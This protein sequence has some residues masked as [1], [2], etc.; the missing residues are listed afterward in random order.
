M[1]KKLHTALKSLMLLFMLSA[2]TVTYSQVGTLDT[3]FDPDE[4]PDFVV[5]IAAPL[6]DGKILIGGSFSEY[7]AVSRKGI[8][9]INADGTLDTSFNPGTGIP[10]M[11]GVTTITINDIEV[12][13]N[14]KILVAGA[15]PTFNDAAKNCMVRLNTDGSLDATF[16]LDARITNMVDVKAITLQPD[17]K[18]II[19]GSFKITGARGG[20]ARLNSDGSIDESFEFTLPNASTNNP[21]F[22]TSLLQ[23]D[24]KILVGGSI[25]RTASVFV[26][27]E[28]LNADGSKDE[29]FSSLLYTSTATPITSGGAVTSLALQAD[30]K[31]I[32]G[33]GFI[34]EAGSLRKLNLIRL[35]ANGTYDATFN[36]G[37]TVGTGL[38]SRVN[39]IKIQPDGKI[40]IAGGFANFNGTSRRGLARINAN[41]S[42]DTSFAVGNGF[43]ATSVYTMN[44]MDDENLI[45]AGNF[46]TYNDFTRNRIAKIATRTITINS[47][48]ATGPFC[49]GAAFDL[50]YTPVGTYNAGNVFTAQLSDASGSFSTPVNIGTFASSVAGTIN[51]TIPQN[52]PSGTGYKIRVVSAS[53][54]ATGDIFAT[55]IALNVTPA[56][57]AV[58]QNF[59][60]TATVS[61]L[62]A[63]LVENAVKNWY[64]TATSTSALLP[65]T[66]LVSGNYYVT[67]TLNGCESSRVSV[68]VLI[69]QQIAPTFNAIPALCFGTTAPL[70]AAASA[71]GITGTWSPATVSNTETATYTFTPNAGQCAVT[72]TVTITVNETPS[73]TGTATQDFTTGQTLAAFAVS[74]TGIK[75]YDAPSGGNELPLTTLIVSG[76][77]YYAS[78][79]VSGCEG[80]SRLPITAGID[81]GTDTFKISDLKYYPNPANEYLNVSYSSN[82]D[83]ITIYTL[84]GQQ[85]LLSNPK[86]TVAKIDTAALHSGTYL[87]KIS[88]GTATKTVK[89]VKK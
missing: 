46:T 79:T 48:A 19:T 10:V 15:F 22:Y 21:N 53:P 65:S 87:L 11:T 42:L 55:S 2:G 73:P 4:G 38:T 6:A 34:Y 71:N 24:G 70:L 1:K 40:I 13:S 28:R 51:A 7:N 72:A 8:A 67:Q 25:N 64:A 86:S 37:T 75:W 78:Q 3:S 77:T 12:L 43:L 74:G 33:G 32:A 36:T 63:T 16:T 5:N 57:T 35:N 45:I 56:P 18:I 47:I 9:R 60:G 14:G 76:V 81:L 44:V 58:A 30:G 82:I 29:S 17:G 69:S 85:V 49:A 52:T 88:A 59:C 41:G 84:L 26:L 23:P 50:N 27:L 61:N 20:I 66:P 54:V 83:T 80:T 62:Q 39:A 31:I 68:A 89:F